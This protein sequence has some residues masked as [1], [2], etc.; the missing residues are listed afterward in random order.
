[1]AR[2]RSIQRHRD[3]Q[4]N[5]NEDRPN[6][7]QINTIL[8]GLPV[9]KESNNAKKSYIQEVYSLYK[10]PIKKFW[11]D[12]IIS[13][14]DKDYIKI[15]TPHE[16]ALVITSLIAYYTVSKILMDN[17]SSVDILYHHALSRMDL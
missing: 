16:D 10:Q 5:N 2:D 3:P 7:G 1:M 15:I 14:S 6:R 9:G 11:D 17:S 12:Q 8:G 13:F 4:Q